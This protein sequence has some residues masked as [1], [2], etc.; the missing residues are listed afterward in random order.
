MKSLSKLD[1]AEMLP[2]EMLILRTGQLHG[3]TT[4]LDSFLELP[5]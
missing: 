2:L 3:V 5:G 1:S 4:D